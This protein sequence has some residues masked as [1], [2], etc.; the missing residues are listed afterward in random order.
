VAQAGRHTLRITIQETEKTMEM[1]LEGRVAGPWAA[2]L[3]L[4]WAETAPRLTQRKLSLD[5]RN[6]TYVDDKGKRVL[7]AI[8][9]ETNAAF[10]TDTPLT[11][12]LAEEIAA[13]STESH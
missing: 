9:A 7:E 1:K 13:G 12:F 10:I 5:L 11:K 6:I 3:S 8:Y 4:M 2:E